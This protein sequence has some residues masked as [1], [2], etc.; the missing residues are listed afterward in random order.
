VKNSL[1]VKENY[2]YALD[3]TLHLSRIFLAEIF[4]K[5][6]ADTLSDP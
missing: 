1:N 3:I 6:D 2:K 5:F 4:I